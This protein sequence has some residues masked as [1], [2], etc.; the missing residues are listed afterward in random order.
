MELARI[1]GLVGDDLSPAT[2]TRF[3]GLWATRLV[4]KGDYLA[5]QGEEAASEF[6]VLDGR[7]VSNIGDQSGRMVCVGFHKGPVVITPHLA[8][9]RDGKSLVS[10]EVTKDA[11]V[12]FMDA[13]KLI[14]LM[15]QSGEIRAWANAFLRSELSR[16]TDREWCLAA[17]RGTDRLTW[18]RTRYP[19]FE[20]DFSHGSIASF[21]GMTPVTLS[22]LRNS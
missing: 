19:G 4:R 21:L 2:L 22:R 5:R 7:V 10:L 18:F 11:T 3:A 6:V 12:A 9:S 20:D 13:S 8:R 1:I 14:E 15:L 17:L 16:K